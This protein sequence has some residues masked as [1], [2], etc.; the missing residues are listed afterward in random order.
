MTKPMLELEHITKKY[1]GVVAL[2]DVSIS[3]YPGEVH[4]IVGENGAGKSTLIKLIT[5]AIGPTSGKILY[6]GNEITDNN[7]EKAIELGIT[8]VYQELNL[9]KHLSVAEN[10]YFNRYP[11]KHGFVDY[12]KMDFYKGLY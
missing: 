6:E 3:F 2:D 11:K 5:G 12:R 7:P 9:L 4:A 10:I 1:P 8:A